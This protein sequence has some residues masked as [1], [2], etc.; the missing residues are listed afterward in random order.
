MKQYWIR[1]EIGI[2]AKALARI[3]QHLIKTIEYNLSFE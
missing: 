2:W 1:G 3:Y